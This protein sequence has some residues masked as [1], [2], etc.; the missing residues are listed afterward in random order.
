MFRF[1]DSIDDIDDYNGASLID[2]LRIRGIGNISDDYIVP[3]RPDRR[4]Q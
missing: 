4:S 1:V 2:K 3:K